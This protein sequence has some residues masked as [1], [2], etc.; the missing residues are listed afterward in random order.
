M[1]MRSGRE[2]ERDVGDPWGRD[3]AT[4][5]AGRRDVNRGRAG[6]EGAT[7]RVAGEGLGGPDRGV[8]EMPCAGPAVEHRRIGHGQAD[9]R[10]DKEGE[11][12]GCEPA[13][14][15]CAIHGAEAN[16]GL[17]E[18]SFLEFPGVTEETRRGKER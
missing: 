6:E 11:D 9:P 5:L 16:T 4:I 17:G 10:A 12:E 7:G 1:V 2:A 3:Q 8:A 15:A 13:G 18:G 14:E